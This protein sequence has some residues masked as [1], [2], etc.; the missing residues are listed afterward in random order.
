[1]SPEVVYNSNTKALNVNMLKSFVGFFTLHPDPH[2]LKVICL[3]G[4]S[5]THFTAT[6]S[7]FAASYDF[8]VDVSISHTC[9]KQNIWQR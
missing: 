5:A 7:I 2:L 3:A 8:I 6:F 9:N 1:M 4:F